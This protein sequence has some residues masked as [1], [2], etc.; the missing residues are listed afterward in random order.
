MDLERPSQTT[1]KEVLQKEHGTSSNLVYDT[2]IQCLTHRTQ[3]S[4]HIS[5]IV[6]SQ[7]NFSFTNILVSYIHN[8]HFN[9]LSTPKPLVIAMPTRESHVHV[10]VMCSKDLGMHLKIRSS[11]HDFEGISYVSDDAFFILDMFNL[12][13]IDMDIKEE[14]AW[15]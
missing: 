3:S 8:G 13:S 1:K 4:D 7:A 2:F 12:R 14:T 6:Y 15:V 5:D 10:A 9:L 11:G